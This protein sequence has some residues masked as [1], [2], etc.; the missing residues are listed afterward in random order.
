MKWIN[1]LRLFPKQKVY[2]IAVE[3]DVALII[4]GQQLINNVHRVIFDAEGN[5]FCVF[6]QRKM[7][8]ASHPVWLLCQCPAEIPAHRII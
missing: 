8:K 5:V 4:R 2:A 3:Y 6:K 7:T 1:P